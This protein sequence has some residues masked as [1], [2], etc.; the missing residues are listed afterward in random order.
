MTNSW[1]FYLSHLTLLKGEVLQKW[2]INFLETPTFASTVA[3]LAA[4][5]VLRVFSS[6]GSLTVQGFQL[7]K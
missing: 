7:I 2:V 4:T 5:A 6:H 3:L 1:K